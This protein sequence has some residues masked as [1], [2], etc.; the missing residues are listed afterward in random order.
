MSLLLLMWHHH[1]RN[2]E[3]IWKLAALVVYEIVASIGGI[4]L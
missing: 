3:G 2:Y 1:L 4:Y